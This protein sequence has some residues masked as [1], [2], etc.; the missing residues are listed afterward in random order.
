MSVFAGQS[1]AIVNAG[2][3]NIRW[4]AVMYQLAH[5]LLR[6]LDDPKLLIWLIKRGGQLHDQLIWLIER[7]LDELRSVVER[8]LVAAL[9]PTTTRAG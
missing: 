8:P 7:R 5:W 1:Q 4:D 3:R 6:H 2:P 9:R